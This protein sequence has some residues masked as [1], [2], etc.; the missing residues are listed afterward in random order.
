MS[1]RSSLAGF[2]RSVTKNPET[3]ELLPT[4][5]EGSLTPFASWWGPRCRI[6]H[7]K[8]ASSGSTTGRRRRLD[9]TALLVRDCA[10]VRLP[11]YRA[12][13]HHSRRPVRIAHPRPQRARDPARRRTHERPRQCSP[14]RHCP[15]AVQSPRHSSVAP[16]PS[17]SHGTAPLSRLRSGLLPPHRHPRHV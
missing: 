12:W 6:Y 14:P 15:R 3:S 2:R 16:V 8:A 13:R 11:N 5:W 9:P 10:P 17:R 4:Q 1:R 7:W